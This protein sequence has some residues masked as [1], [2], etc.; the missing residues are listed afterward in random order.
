MPAPARVHRRNE[1]DARREGD[2][3]VRPGNADRTGLEWLPKRIQHRA[4]E[5]RKLIEEKDA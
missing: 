4:L 3:R 1:L 5:L 2:V